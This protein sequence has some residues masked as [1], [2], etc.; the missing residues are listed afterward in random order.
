M[1]D[2]I[3]RNNVRL[4][5]LVPSLPRAKVLP[6]NSIKS[7]NE[8]TCE[9]I[10]S[11]G[12]PA[13]ASRGGGTGGRAGRGGGKTRGPS[14]DQGDG[15]IESQGGQVAQVGDHGRG[16]GN[17]R[18]QSGDAINDNIWGDVIR[19]YT[20][21]EFLACNPKEYDGKGASHVVELSNPHT[22]SK[23]LC[24]FHELARLVPHLVTPEGKRFE[25][26]IASTLTDEDLR[27]GSIK[28]N[29][30]KRGN[31]GEPSKDRNV[32][33]EN[34]RT[35]TGNVF[36]TT[37]NAVRGG[38]TGIEPS[39]LGFSYKIEIASRQ[40]V[41]IDKVIK[42]CKLE[43]EE[44]SNDTTTRWHGSYSIR[45][46]TEEKVRQLM[47]ART[48][49]HKQKEII[50]VKYFPEVFPDDLSGL[51]PVREIKFRIELVLGAMLIAKSPYRLEPSK[52]EELSGQLKELHDKALNK[53]T[54]KNHYLLPR[55]DD[56]FDQLQ[57]S[58][59]FS[60]IDLRSGYHQL[61]VHE[62]DILKTAFRTR[63]GHFEFTIMPFGLTN[64]PATWEEHE[65]HQGLVLELLRKEKLYAKFSKCE[66]WLQEVQF[67]GH[68]I[69][70][71][72]IHVDPN[73][74][75]AGEEQENAFQTLKDKL[76][77]APVLA[78]PG[79]S[80]YDYEIYY[81]PGKENV[82]V[83]ALSRKERVKSKRVKAM[84]MTLQSSI[85]DK[86]LAAQKEA[87]DESTRLQKGLDEMIEHRSDR[88]LYYLDRI[89]VL[90]KG[91]VKTLIM[92]EAHKS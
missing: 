77:N 47:C 29:H 52:L 62:D 16:Q 23:S 53:L 75:E 12:R 8:K 84:N 28:K 15:R 39:E 4:T 40:L 81:H 36:A 35:R 9:N 43:I 34:K 76:C 69:N 61:R 59:Y 45:R 91:D 58:Q 80:D 87:C 3:G 67:L 24:R 25:R 51:P 1:I 26:Y 48:K 57:G 63:Y 27:N 19:G 6:A 30:E 64:A 85:K 86:I 90:L 44:S 32:R 10:S 56:L 79:G 18:N 2:S 71:G 65:V 20:Y 22:R 31:K 17:G 88:A 37:A 33:D 78:L 83:Y 41:E 5:C 60:K 38:Y 89:W 49:G 74:I 13:T 68:V 11:A 92:D 72:G 73:K 14:G 42:G 7:S 50:V 54:I 55:I 21:K 46:E 82:V 70:G 66:F